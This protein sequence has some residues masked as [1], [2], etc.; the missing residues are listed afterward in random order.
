MKILQNVCVF[1]SM[2]F[3]LGGVQGPEAPGHGVWGTKSPEAEANF[4]KC[5]LICIFHYFVY[6]KTNI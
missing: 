4:A 1:F 6:S 3:S 2:Y 5:R